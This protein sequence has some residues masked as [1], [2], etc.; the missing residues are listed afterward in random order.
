[1]AV[2]IAVAESLERP[3]LRGR[4]WN[5]GC[6][7]PVAAIEVV[8]ALIAL[9]GLEL[10]PDIRGE[11]VPPGEIERQYLDSGA[12]RAELGWTPEWELEQGL[13][14][15]WEWYSRLLAT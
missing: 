10:E 4:A 3:E 5:A 12:I 2:Y 8:R 13:E 1:V 14:A 6:G 11:G 9:S 15:A 7:R